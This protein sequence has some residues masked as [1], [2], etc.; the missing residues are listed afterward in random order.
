M[1]SSCLALLPS[2]DVIS[3]AL[4]WI[5]EF[6]HTLPFSRTLDVFLNV[7]VLKIDRRKV[8]PVELVS[9]TRI[10][11]GASI[12]L[13]TRLCG[14]RLQFMNGTVL[15]DEASG[16]CTG[17]A[18]GNSPAH[19]PILTR[20]VVTLSLLHCFLHWFVYETVFAEEAWVTLASEAAGNTATNPSILAG[21]FLTFIFGT[22]FHIAP[23]PSSLRVG[24]VAPGPVRGRVR[25][26]AVIFGRGSAPVRVLV[27][28]RGPVV[29]VGG[30]GGPGLARLAGLGHAHSPRV[31]PAHLGLSARTGLTIRYL[32]VLPSN[33]GVGRVAPWV[34][35]RVVL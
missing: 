6:L 12:Q 32:A 18:A 35:A 23:V 5:D 28:G 8:T 27:D 17:K 31:L 19:S 11:V 22:V 26:A 30:L 13:T 25:A 4:G 1:T 9:D 20:S 33:V 3:I 24:S 21:S 7:W 34:R 16:T 2:D 14:R 29:L 15:A 10:P